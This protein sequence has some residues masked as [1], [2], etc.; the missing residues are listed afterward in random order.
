VTTQE[1][2]ASDFWCHLLH[3][4]LLL[5]IITDKARAKG[6]RKVEGVGAMKDEELKLEEIQV[7]HTLGGAGESSRGEGSEGFSRVV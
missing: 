4:V 3:E 1:S 6:G 2:T 5:F 7:S